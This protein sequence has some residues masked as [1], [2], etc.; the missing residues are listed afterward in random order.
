MRRFIRRKGYKED[1]IYIEN[2]G[3]EEEAYANDPN[4]D[5]SLPPR[6]IFDFHFF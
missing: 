1:E 4:F 2:N 5:E 6:Y 3:Y